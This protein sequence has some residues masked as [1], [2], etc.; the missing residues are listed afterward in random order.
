MKKRSRPKRVQKEVTFHF[1][2][3][4]HV[5]QI[6]KPTYID[7]LER[8]IK[9]AS[10]KKK[11]V[12][13]AVEIPNEYIRLLK[14]FSKSL[15]EEDI[16]KLQPSLLAGALGLVPRSINGKIMPIDRQT[17][18]SLKSYLLLIKKYPKIT[19]VGLEITGL[20]ANK[21]TQKQM[22]ILQRAVK[23]LQAEKN[24]FF[25]KLLRVIDETNDKRK[26]ELAESLLDFMAKNRAFKDSLSSLIKSHDYVI[27]AGG[28]A[29]SII[30]PSLV[31]EM[32]RYK[33]KEIKLRTKIEHAS[34]SSAKAI[35]MREST[36]FNPILV[37]GRAADAG[38]LDHLPEKGIKEL[39]D[40]MKE[41]SKGINKNIKIEGLETVE[42]AL[43]SLKRKKIEFGEKKLPPS[44]AAA[45][46]VRMIAEKYKS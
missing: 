33:K 43:K 22:Q 7:R 44:M 30:I 32:A 8:A 34:K 35:G 24:P 10:E 29:H 16:K 5:K 14:E 41:I 17:M 21:P 37:V 9:N 19:W 38:L 26:K 13:V 42:E 45:K 27:Y 23:N 25:N 12:A 15:D 11:R 36:I 2:G 1:I 20:M 39:L 28:S 3:E 6:A 40:G 31:K 46:L 4:M 18:T